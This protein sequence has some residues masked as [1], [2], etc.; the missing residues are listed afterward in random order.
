[1]HSPNRSV[2]QGLRKG[3]GK[4]SGIRREKNKKENKRDKHY[5]EIKQNKSKERRPDFA[6]GK[7]AILQYIQS[8]ELER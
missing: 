5:R 8:R 6:N 4:S 3:R 2:E 1:M 7:A